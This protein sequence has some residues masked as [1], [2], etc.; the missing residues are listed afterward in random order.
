MNNFTQNLLRSVQEMYRS[1]DKTL[2]DKRL[3]NVSKETQKMAEN[4]RRGMH[5]YE[6]MAKI[7]TIGEIVYQQ[8]PF[9]APQA[10]SMMPLC[11]VNTAG[12]RKNVKEQINSDFSAQN[13]K[14]FFKDNAVCNFVV[15]IIGYTVYE[16][17]KGK[18]RKTYNLRI[19]CRSKTALHRATPKEL[20]SEKFYLY[21]PDFPNLCL[22][23][24]NVDSGVI[25]RGYLL[26]PAQCF[27]K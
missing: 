1:S 25:E 11:V 18:G 13:G 3:D 27:A 5:N 7:Q 15:Q 2:K 12:T 23:D 19:S 22:Y 16:H 4:V 21:L 9:L 8:N 24:K 10:I 14:V 6:N 26:G 20:R 17:E